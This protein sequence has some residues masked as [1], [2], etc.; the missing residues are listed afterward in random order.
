MN[1]KSNETAIGIGD[2]H[3]CLSYSEASDIKD[4]V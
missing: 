2:N 1:I 3:T 4:Y